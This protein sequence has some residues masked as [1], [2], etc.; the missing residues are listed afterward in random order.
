[1]LKK[2]SSRLLTS[3][4]VAKGWI[5][6]Q[7]DGKNAF[8]HAVLPDNETVIVEPPPGCPFS[9]PGNLCLLNKIMCRL[10]WSPFHS[11]NKFGK[12]LVRIGLSP[13]A[14]WNYP[15]GTSMH[16]SVRMLTI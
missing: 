10:K 7:G 14:Y 5:E 4:A 11:Y 15:P 1:M 16:T 13:C 9:K 12:A 8:L 2:S 6:K 3:L